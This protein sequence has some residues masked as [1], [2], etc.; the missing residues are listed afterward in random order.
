MLTTSL[1]EMLGIAYPIMQGALGPHDT[2]GLAAAV[3]KAGGLGMISS[4]HGPD[5]YR[6]TQ[7]QLTYLHTMSNPFGI[8]IPVKSI[9]GPERLNATLD[10]LSQRPNLRRTLKVVVTAAGNP[11]TFAKAIREANLHHFH[12]VASVDQAMKAVV[13]G[14]SGL[15]VEGNESG[16]HVAS[17]DGPT[18]MTLIPAVAASVRI[19]VI[20]AGGITDGKGLIAALALGAVGIQMGTRFFMSKEAGFAPQG[21]QAALLAAT[22]ADTAVI[23]SVYGPNRHWKNHYVDDLLKL[24]GDADAGIAIK[25]LK[26]DALIAY[27]QGIS[28]RA[29]VPIGMGI[30]RIESVLSAGEL[31]TEIIAEGA[32]IIS[33]LQAT[34][35]ATTLKQNM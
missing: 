23:P 25:Q 17:A 21:I 8:N 3:S 28:H 32:M 4:I 7:D 33:R 27:A 26:S 19:P 30:G 13:A 10:L 14:C 35:G 22:V 6:K 29:T 5:V 31:I 11:V 1:C 15:I 2:A 18:S 20:A 12:V 24:V 9:E 34:I 16:G